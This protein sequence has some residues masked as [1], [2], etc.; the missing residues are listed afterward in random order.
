[1]KKILLMM[2]ALCAVAFVSCDKDDENGGGSLKVNGVN[3]V[4][5]W[6]KIDDD[7]LETGLGSWLIKFT[8]STYQEYCVSDANCEKWKNA[9]IPFSQWGFTFKDGYFYGCTMADFE[10]D[11]VEHYTAEV[12]NGKLRVAGIVLNIKVIDK[13]NIEF[14]GSRRYQRVKGFK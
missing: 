10:P 5:L 6:V 9:G 3:L 1:M 4:G 13:D 7:Y 14:D 11:E 2:V 8:N 12:V